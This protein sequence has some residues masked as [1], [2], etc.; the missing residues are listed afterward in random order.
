MNFY[1]DKDAQS[2]LEDLRRC[3]A[4]DFNLIVVLLR[5]I[6]Q[7]KTLLSKLT[8]DGLWDAPSASFDVTQFQHFF[9][10]GYDIWRLKIVTINHRSIPY[11]IIYAYDRVK[12]DFHV[13]AI[14]PRSVNYESDS[15]FTQRLRDAYNRIGLTISRFH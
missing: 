1:L 2:D 9:K 7:D 4:K 15:S 5:E 12:F 6:K 14:M 11:R 10:K 13:L 3:N 8:D